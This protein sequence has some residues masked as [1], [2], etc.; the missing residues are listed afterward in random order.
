[1]DQEIIY[2]AAQQRQYTVGWIIW[3][4]SP[5]SAFILLRRLITF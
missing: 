1:M 4:M 5:M 2:S 3:Q